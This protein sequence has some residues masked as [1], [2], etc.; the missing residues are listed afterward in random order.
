LI[1]RLHLFFIILLF[2]SIALFRQSDADFGNAD[3]ILEKIPD[4]FVSSSQHTDIQHF[5]LVEKSSQQ[6]FLYSYDGVTYKK[7]LTM[8]C[9]TGKAIGS[10]KK[11]GDK[12]TPEGIYFFTKQYRDKDLA[13]IYGTRAFPMDFPNSVDKLNSIGGSA[14]WLHGSNKPIKPMDSNGCIVVDNK[15]IDKLE[16]YIYVKKTPIVV[17]DKIFYKSIDSYKDKVEAMRSLIYRKKDALYSGTYHDYLACYGSGF[18]PEIMWWRDWLKVR[19]K[20]EEKKLSF[21]ITIDNISIL[22]HNK[23]YVAIFDEY[24][25]DEQSKK[26]NFIRSDKVFIKFDS[27]NYPKFIGEEFLALPDKALYAEKRHPVLIASEELA[28]CMGDKKTQQEISATLKG[29]LEAWSA[30]DIKSYESYYSDN[31][32]SG[33]MDIKAWLQ[34]KKTLNKKYKYIKVSGESFSTKCKENKCVVSFIQNYESD[35][36]QVKGNKSI[37]LIRKNKKWK[38]YRESYK[39][40]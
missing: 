8:P 38:I 33:D 19:N 39:K 2:L 40:L 12:K 31:F 21:S 22:K 11:A 35:Q 4:V 7:V 14:I 30:K 1:N 25:V 36:Y 34:Y 32:T 28:A 15:N 16:K 23:I 5:I 37:W 26:K 3:P 17:V 27:E 10:K 18:L 24:I 29:W 9:S 20:M 6:V 13:P